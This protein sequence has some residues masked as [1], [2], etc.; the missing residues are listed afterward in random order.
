MEFVDKEFVYVVI[1][2]ASMTNFNSSLYVFFKKCLQTAFI[3]VRISLSFYDP[4]VFLS[5]NYWVIHLVVIEIHI[6]K[7]FY[8]DIANAGLM[9][10]FWGSLFDFYFFTSKGKLIIIVYVTFLVVGKAAVSVIYL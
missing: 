7:A 4:S 10:I 1:N 8:F 2:R 6:D 5:I 3:S 9:I